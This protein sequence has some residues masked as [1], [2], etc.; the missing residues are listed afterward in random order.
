[1][2]RFFKKGEAFFGFMR[3][4]RN[5]HGEVVIR[6]V[7]GRILVFLSALGLAGWLTAALAVMLFVKHSRDFQGG[8]YMDI[9]FPW[10]WEAY[11]VAWGEEFIERGLELLNEGEFREGMH[12]VR[13]GHLKSPSN[14][15]GRLF[16][17]DFHSARGRTDLAAN[18]LRDGLPYAEED[19]DYVRTTLRLLISSHEDQAV[20]KVANRLLPDEVVITPRNQVIALAAAT[21][22]FHRGRYDEAEE[23]LLRYDL[24]GN[25]EGR[26]LLVRLDWE[27]GNQAA[28]IER[29]EAL[30]DRFTEQEEVYILLAR[31][32]RELGNHSRAHNYEV[33]RQV[34]DPLSAPPRVALLYS[35]HQ[36]GDEARVRR[37][38]DQLLTDFSHD[39][40][41]LLGLGEFAAYSGDIEL[42]RQVFQLM[43][44]PGFP[45]HLP[46]ILM[47]ET[48]LKAGQFRESISFLEDYS[49]E[50]ETLETQFGPVLDSIYA[51]AYLGIGNW[52]S[53]EMHLNR[54]LNARQMRAETLLITS[55]RLVGIGQLSL[56]R[57]VMMQ[58]HQ[59]NPRNQAALTELIR[60]DLKAGHTDDLVTNINKLLGM[61]KPPRAL[62]EESAATLRADQFLFLPQRDELLRS[63][64]QMMSDPSPGTDATHS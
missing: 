10:R 22:H 25:S 33:M 45:L 60:L 40:E 31:Y 23:F 48:Y 7:L 47:A 9:V 24:A 63:I 2:A 12:M 11:Q 16:M 30:A 59:A 8:N 38:A 42:C 27:R 15:D 19:L 37:V 32:N 58:A 61:R 36:A 39:Q 20:I 53:G 17:A 29:L 21:A 62:L 64:Q 34:S 50:D 35:H 57:R 6:P 18:L 49:E 46:A 5:K 41:A 1:M 26:L 13:V 52:D 14:L 3:F 28:A 56:A 4:A 51:V 43:D 55:E 44:R 54:F